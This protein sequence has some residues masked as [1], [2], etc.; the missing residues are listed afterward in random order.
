MVA[1]SRRSAS[2]SGRPGHSSHRTAFPASAPAPT[3]S[4]ALALDALEYLRQERSRHLDVGAWADPAF[5]RV[6]HAVREDL[7]PIRSRRALAESFRREAFHIRRPVLYPDGAPTGP[8]SPVRL[9]YAI[10]WLE[11]GDGEPRPAWKP[12]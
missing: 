7:A 6:V 5:V 9:A 11:L 3:P 10:R 12:S 4:R 1:T 2:L 8:M